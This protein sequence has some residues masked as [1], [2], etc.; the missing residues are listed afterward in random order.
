MS[1]LQEFGGVDGWSFVAMGVKSNGW[2]RLPMNTR[3]I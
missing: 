2:S 1:I 3:I